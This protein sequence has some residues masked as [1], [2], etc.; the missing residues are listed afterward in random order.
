MKSLKPIG[1]S[2]KEHL[3]EILNE[4]Q[5]SATECEPWQSLSQESRLD[6]LP[7]VVERLVDV[8]LSPR[9]SRAVR[10]AEVRTAAEHGE[11]RLR[12]GVPEDALITEY[13]L[14]RYVITRF[15]R[16]HFP[17]P[18]AQKAILRLSTSTTIALAASLWGYHRNEL[19][20]RQEWPKALDQLADSWLAR[21]RQN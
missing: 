16:E 19:E 11:H 9:P 13:G 2:I 8:A 7:E 10:L 1:K 12:M 18:E 6:N 15:V 21:A 17:T 4:W 3:P 14:L 20:G 5:A